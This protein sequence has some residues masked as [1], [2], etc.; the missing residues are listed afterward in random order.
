MTDSFSKFTASMGKG[1][2]AVSMDREYL[3]RRRMHMAKN[4]PRHAFGGVVQG[5]NYFANGLLSGAT[6]LVVSLLGFCSN[7]DMLISTQF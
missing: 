6:G 7:A 4:R 2:S 1:L 3:D 5:A